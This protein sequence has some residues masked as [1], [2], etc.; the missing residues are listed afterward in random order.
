M[1]DI[2]ERD[3]RAQLRLCQG[4]AIWRKWCSEWHAADPHLT[5]RRQDQLTQHIVDTLWGATAYGVSPRL[6]R[7]MMMAAKLAIR[8]H[9]PASSNQGKP[10]ADTSVALLGPGDGAN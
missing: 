1:P 6:R 4:E 7:N 9:W 5:A 3:L 10:P 8:A 2:H